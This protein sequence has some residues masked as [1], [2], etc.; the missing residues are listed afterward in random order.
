M[1][2]RT[3]T[4][5]PSITVVFPTFNEEANVVA[6]VEGV[7]R[8]LRDRHDDVEVVVV[9]DGS[10]D[11]TP[12][13]A[14]GLA[15]AYADVKAVHHERNYKLGR[16][17]RTGFAAATKDLLFYTDADLPIDFRD[18]HR[19]VELLLRDGADVVAGYR[20]ERGDSWRRGIY[21]VVYNRLVNALFGL[22]VKDV[23]FS[24]KLFTKEAFR[25][26]KLTSEGSF[27][28]AEM[29][30]RAK[31]AGMRVAQIGVHYFPRRAGR[32]TLASPGVILKILVEMSR[33]WWGV[34]RRGGGA[35]DEPQR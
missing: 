6:S 34:W 24:Y 30:A 17:L 3:H 14:D 12:A 18:I 15:A 33:F 31:L 28:D 9:D 32:S 20:L 21:S 25:K 27:I 13:L 10:T 22:G 1:D 5:K 11:R 35:R 4:R 19:G 8:A 29:L 26:L 2:K 7:R 23:N 16:T